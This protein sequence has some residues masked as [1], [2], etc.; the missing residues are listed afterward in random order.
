M[1]QIREEGY[2]DYTAL[3]AFELKK[4]MSKFIGTYIAFKPKHAQ[5]G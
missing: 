1:K 2:F 3:I 4:K 5:P